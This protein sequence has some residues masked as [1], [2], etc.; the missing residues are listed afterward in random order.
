MQI[1]SVFDPDFTPYGKVVDGLD[2]ARLLE[3]LE[4]TTQK[5]EDS[6]TYLPSDKAL[7]ALDIFKQLRD[8]A[9]GGMPIQIGYCNGNNRKLNCLEYHRDSEINIPGDDIILLLAKLQDVKDGKLD[10]K[11][12]QA[13]L[14]PVG[15]PV[16][17]YETTLHY[18]PCNAPGKSGFRVAVVLPRDTNTERPEIKIGGFEDRLL[19]A[20]N[21][22]LIAH[23]DSGEAAAGAFVGLTGE[24][25]TL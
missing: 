7:E 5:P 2:T 4:S 22:W 15:T 17:L 23:P 9:Y 16:Q 13:F 6:V 24:N 25:I 21:K 20:R 19:W 8:N 10:T 12:V 11:K 18:A 14:A 3:M 1:L